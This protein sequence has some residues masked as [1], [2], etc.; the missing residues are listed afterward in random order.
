MPTLFND[1]INNSEEFNISCI[2]IGDTTAPTI[3]VLRN[4]F[5]SLISTKLQYPGAEE[6]F[7]DTA[8]KYNSGV[9]S[10]VGT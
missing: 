10:F 6:G 5:S 7:F 8:S 9:L 4:F 2:D 3:D 1:L